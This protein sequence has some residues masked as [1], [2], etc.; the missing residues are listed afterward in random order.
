MRATGRGRVIRL[1]FA[2]LLITFAALSA[3]SSQATS[4]QESASAFVNTLM[5]QPAQV[6]TH[7]G[8][9]VVTPSFTVIADHF[10]DTR[11]DAAIE[12]NLERIKSQTATLIATSLGT[13]AANP[14]PAAR[15]PPDPD[16]RR[17]KCRQTP[18]RPARQAN[19]SPAH[20]DWRSSGDP[21]KR[22]NSA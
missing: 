19:T 5:P 18:L 16:A 17:R 14:R 21:G 11:L 12:R 13:R 20:T 4:S 8:R 6:S 3:A 2:I 7:G 10:R 1:S 15:C 9:L 22:W